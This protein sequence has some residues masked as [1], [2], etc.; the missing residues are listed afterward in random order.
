MFAEV[1]ILQ[2]ISPSSGFKR[3]LSFFSVWF[4]AG[5]TNHSI[6]LIQI[7]AVLAGPHSIG[8]LHFHA[9]QKPRAKSNNTDPGPGRQN[10]EK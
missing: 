7:L 5:L 10:Y 6:T 1:R 2:R 3:I 9:D 8:L 4:L